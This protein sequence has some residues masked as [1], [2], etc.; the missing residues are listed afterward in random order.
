MVTVCFC[1]TEGVLLVKDLMIQEWDGFQVSSDLGVSS[2][3][4]HCL[5]AR[6]LDEMMTR[7]TRP[8]IHP[9]YTQAFI[10]KHNLNSFLKN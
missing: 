8:E 10:C 6:G 1:H 4:N 5:I 3:L 2:L 9:K 7:M